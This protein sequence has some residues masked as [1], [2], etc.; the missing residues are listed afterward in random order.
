MTVLPD[1]LSDD[2]TP[3][4]VPPTP[5]QP[6]SIYAVTAQLHTYRFGPDG[7]PQVLALHGLTGHGRRWEHIAKNHLPDVPM[8]APDLIGHG[9]SSWAAPWSFDSNIEAL[10]ALLESEGGNPVVVVGHSF[11]CAV[12]LQL[13]HHRP[14][15]VRGLVLLDPA[16]GLDGTWMAEIA[17]AMLA[18]PDYPDPAEARE[19][20]AGGSW[21][22]VAPE[23][24]DADMDEHLITLPNGRYGWRIS[25]P[26]MV[27]YWSELARPAVY[28]HPGTPTVVARALWTDPPYVSA[29]LLEGLRARLGDDLRPVDLDCLHMVAQAKPAETATLIRELLD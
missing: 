26:A 4:A 14:D 5:G 8:L 15:L 19:E 25:V 10:S 13:A 11:G 7:P 3:T 18:S 16:V 28:P 2:L 20:K 23:L 9:R 1:V 29:E 21:A 24:L 12:A 22:D 27:S 17:E 6:G